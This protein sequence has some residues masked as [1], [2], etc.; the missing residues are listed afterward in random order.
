LTAPAPN[1]YNQKGSDS[2][3][4][5]DPMAGGRITWH[6]TDAEALWFRGDVAGFDISNQ[7]HVQ[8]PRDLEWRV[9]PSASP[10]WGSGA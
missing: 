8:P 5:I 4:V 10:S 6:I 9:I 3:T 1:A 7:V 2:G